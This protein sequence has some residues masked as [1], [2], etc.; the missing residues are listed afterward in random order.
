MKNQ[1]VSTCACGAMGTFTSHCGQASTPV[2]TGSA[3]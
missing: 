1:S 3:S 2:V